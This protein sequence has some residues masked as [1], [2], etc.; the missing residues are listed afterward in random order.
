MVLQSHL[1]NKDKLFI[2]GALA[3]VTGVVTA[4]C[5]EGFWKVA[6]PAAQGVRNGISRI[7]DSSDIPPPPG[8][9]VSIGETESSIQ[10]SGEIIMPDELPEGEARKAVEQL[11]QLESESEGAIKVIMSFM[12]GHDGKPFC[13]FLTIEIAEGGK[14]PESLDK[15]IDAFDKEF[16]GTRITVGDVRWKGSDRVADADSSEAVPISG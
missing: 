7:F 5:S 4:V 14:A 8:D 13:T 16:P 11:R 1:M 2:G 12:K 6:N 10:A 15:M 9:P 3:A